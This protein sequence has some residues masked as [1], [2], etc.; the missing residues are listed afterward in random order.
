CDGIF[1]TSKW[2]PGEYIKEMFRLRVPPNAPAEMGLDLR[3]SEPNKP[4]VELHLGAVAIAPLAPASAPA[5]APAPA[6][7]RPERTP[8]TSNVKEPRAR[9]T[10]SPGKP[11]AC[12]PTIV[13]PRAWRAGVRRIVRPCRTPASGGPDLLPKLDDGDA[14]VMD[15]LSAHKDPRVAWAC[16]ERGIR[17]IYPPPHSPERRSRRAAPRTGG[18]PSR[19]A[20]CDQ[21]PEPRPARRAPRRPA[22]PPR[23]ARCGQAC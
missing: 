20:V 11:R 9:T 16:V 18:A 17:L 10:E 23:H 19:A 15:N 8:A 12:G 6:P 13:I 2:R 7:A 5:S 1:P 21:G 22:A 4:A 14:L 3:L